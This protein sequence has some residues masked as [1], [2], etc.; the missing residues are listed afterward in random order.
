VINHNVRV[1][2][3]LAV[4][5]R[6]SVLIGFGLLQPIE[7]PP[8]A[9]LAALS[10]K[11]DIGVS[12]ASKIAGAWA[13]V[14]PLRASKS[15]LGGTWGLRS[16]ARAY[17]CYRLSRLGAPH[18]RQADDPHVYPISWKQSTLMSNGTYLPRPPRG[19]LPRPLRPP[20]GNRNLESR[21]DKG[22]FDS[23]QKFR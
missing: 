14:G 10:L 18:E 13:G 12:G 1:K 9:L 16:R 20:R 21:T 8:P 6:T 11:A 5:Q 15:G 19:R 4:R 22:G 17:F 3:L 23:N 7:H 2:R